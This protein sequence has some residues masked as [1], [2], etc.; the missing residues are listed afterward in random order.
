MANVYAILGHGTE[1]IIRPDLRN[2]MQRGYTL[3]TVTM[4]GEISPLL[5]PSHVLDVLKNNIVAARNPRLNK[6]Y[7]ED[8]FGF[9]INVYRPGDQ[10]PALLYSSSAFNHGRYGLSGV[11]NISRLKY[12]DYLLMREGKPFADPSNPTQAELADSYR[13]SLFPSRPPPVENVPIETI[14]LNLPP[15]VYYFAICREAVELPPDVPDPIPFI[16]EFSHHQQETSRNGGRR[17]Q[18]KKRLTRRRKRRSLQIM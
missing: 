4:C 17:K 14:F 6:R 10:Y 18:M 7:L 8:R 11:V 5:R 2:V 1:R 16:R 15:G 12:D 9:P 3:V 13:Q